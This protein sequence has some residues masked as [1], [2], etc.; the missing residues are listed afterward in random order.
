M[1]KV[2]GIPEVTLLLKSPP[3][4][5]QD[6]LKDFRTRTVAGLIPEIGPET[7]IIISRIRAYQR[8]LGDI[9]DT[10]FDNSAAPLPSINTKDD[11]YRAG[12]HERTRFGFTLADQL[13]WSGADEAFRNWRKLIEA[14]GVCVYVDKFPLND[15]R[16]VSV[17]DDPRFPAILLN[18]SEPPPIWWTD[19]EDRV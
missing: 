17:L 18:K 2:Y 4:T 7:N 12:E 11:A 19:R 5:E 3:T 9:A 1:A 15:C 16:G 6:Q 8:K 14:Q 13:N 10:G